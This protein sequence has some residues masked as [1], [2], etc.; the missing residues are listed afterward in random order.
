M[1]LSAER[2]TNNPGRVRRVF[3]IRL[4]A[5]LVVCAA[6]LAAPS[7][8][9][10]EEDNPRRDG[11]VRAVEKAR[12]AVVNINAEEE[13]VRSNP[14]YGFGDSFFDDFF[15]DF[16]ESTPR[17][18]TTQSLGSGVIID[19]EGY[20]LTNEH[21]V[22]RASRIGVTLADERAFKARVVGSD[23]DHDLAVLKVESAE[24]LPAIEIGGS[25][26]L[27]IGEKVIAIGNPFGLSHTVTTGVV[28]ATR[29]SI[30]TSQG[31]VYYDFIQTD[32]AINPGN[33]GGPLLDVNG[34]LIGINTA[35]Y[36]RGDGIGF[37]IPSDVARRAVNDIVRY[38]KI[39][40]VWLGAA[41]KKW[42]I[43]GVGVG[44]RKSVGVEIVRLLKGGPGDRSGLRTGDVVV[45]V[46]D[47]AVGSVGEFLF[48]VGK[49][50]GGDLIPLQV[51]RGRKTI[52]FIVMAV[53]PGKEAI[54][55]IKW[56]WLGLK[57]RETRYGVGIE[58]VR[59]GGAAEVIGLR[60][61]DHILEV[62]GETVGGMED[63]RRE[64]LAAS[65]RGKVMLLVQRGRWGYNVNLRLEE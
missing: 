32:A 37:A 22:A 5:V 52:D 20:I 39:R 41:V 26:D 25:G 23:P 35:I 3:Q 12:P 38:G 10:A 8:P 30:R 44:D 6:L 29:R 40:P 50:S 24:P 11:V 49:Y 13:M 17:R 61:G 31:R 59:E 15:R 62:E 28:S 36:A 55:K 2:L 65:Q 14:F 47:E 7:E 27:L 54:D 9:A 19:S 58:R 57:V 4:P 33:S 53:N 43:P 34:T 18:R 42:R 16:F 64:I 51:E 45:R 60:G 56:E 46:G 1:P 48:R 21:V 63:F